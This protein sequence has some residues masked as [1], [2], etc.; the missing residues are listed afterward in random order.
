MK[1]KQ[2]D[3][4]TPSY[5]KKAIQTAVFS[6]SALAML[7]ATPACTSQNLQPTGIVPAETPPEE[8]LVL[9]GEVGYELP[10]DDDTMLAGE[11][12]PDE[13]GEAEEDGEQ[14]STGREG[15]ALEGKIVVP[16]DE[17]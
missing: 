13:S 8:E 17:P 16:D 14:T 5:P 11:P 6:M 9:D 7:T 1:Q 10:Q 15:P 3:D 2:I 4:Y 12:M